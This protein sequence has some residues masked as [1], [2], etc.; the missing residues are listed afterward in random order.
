LILLVITTVASV[1]SSNA[2]AS[3][4][5]DVDA[6]ASDAGVLIGGACSDTATGN[7]QSDFYV[8]S[9]RTRTLT[10]GYPSSLDNGFWNAQCGTMMR[11]PKGP[12]FGTQIQQNG[13]WVLLNTWCA[14]DPVNAPARVVT[15]AALR[16][17]VLR[18]L[19]T[20]RIGSAW[21]T[22]ALVNAETI[23][24]AETSARRSLGTVTVVGRQVG[25]RIGFDHADWSF[26]DSATDTT[27][28]PGKPYTKS[29]P[30]ETAQ[31][32]DY[33]GHTY[34]DTGHVTITLTVAWHA[35][36]SLDNGA[37]WTAVDPAALT[38]PATTHD[39]AVVQARGI[40][41]QNP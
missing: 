15:T 12:A 30:C 34:T 23:L 14:G 41:V 17:Q 29:D 2:S 9:P 6:G 16:Q 8:P 5:C 35:E 4:T 31:C 13:Q 32:P 11:C 27:T 40:I 36:F 3:A 18:L 39:L 10:C 26:G 19:P 7:G 20:V 25:L 37:T 38:G 28:D 1:P 24:W 21:T 22:R 33:Y